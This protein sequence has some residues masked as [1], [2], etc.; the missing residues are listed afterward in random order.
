MNALAGLMNP[1]AIGQQVQGAF[2][3]GQQKR[4]QQDS[5]NALS[6]YAVDPNSDENFANLA[7][8]NPELAIQ[9]RGQRDKAAQERQMVELRQ[10]ALQGD[11]QAAQQLATVDTQAY[12]RMDDQQRAEV[13]K[14]DDAL[15]EAMFAIVQLPEEQRP[16]AWD[17]YADKLGR[18]D[19]K[20][21]YSPQMMN[22][23]TARQ[24]IQER[25]QKFQQPNYTPVGEGG[26]AGFQYGQPM[27]GGANMAP[28]SQQPMG[29]NDAAPVLQQA[30]ASGVITAQDAESVRQSLGQNGG[31][32][33]DRWKAQNGIRVITRTG[34]DAN[35]RKVFQFEDGT[36]DYGD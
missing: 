13:D 34:T 1:G 10:R 35:G 8:Y 20:G 14:T 11:T 31:A 30:Q 9:V 32:E 28:Q 7:K 27:Q 2:E 15:A 29:P 22:I 23:I 16:Q 24:G 36:V 26:L 4:L 6:A 12:N 18:P 3:Q 21:Q 5:R 17:Y 19:Y 33:F 25:F